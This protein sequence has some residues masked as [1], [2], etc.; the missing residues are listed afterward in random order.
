MLEI[1]HFVAGDEV[2][3]SRLQQEGK[4]NHL[5]RLRPTLHRIT[6]FNPTALHG[7]YRI[8]MGDRPDGLTLAVYE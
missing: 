6:L 8:L 4:S 3:D 1:C 2:N 5:I 7:L